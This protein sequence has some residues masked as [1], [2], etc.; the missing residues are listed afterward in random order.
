MRP[1]KRQ[2]TTDQYHGLTIIGFR[3]VLQTQGEIV[4]HATAG[5]SP[6]RYDESQYRQQD[7]NGNQTG[8]W[9]KPQADHCT[10]Q[11]SP[12]RKPALLCRAHFTA[13][14]SRVSSV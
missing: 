14:G 12:E 8:C 11:G 5:D 1:G 3:Q 2:I 7:E 4:L 6:E 9:Q 10:Q 13:P